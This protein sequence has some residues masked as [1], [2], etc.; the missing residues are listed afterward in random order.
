MYTF[1]HGVHPY[2]GKELVLGVRPECSYLKGDRN[3]EHPSEAIK[4]RI[5]ELFVDELS[6]KE[7]ED[8]A[9]LIYDAESQIERKKAEVEDFDKWCETSI[10]QLIRVM[11]LIHV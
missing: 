4:R 10:Y 8:L 1:K 3:N 2:E 6:D 11:H 5:D 9:A 7:K